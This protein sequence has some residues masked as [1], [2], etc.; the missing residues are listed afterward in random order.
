MS[1]SNTSSVDMGDGY[2]LSHL[3]TQQKNSTSGNSTIPTSVKNATRKEMS[4][5]AKAKAKKKAKLAKASRKKN[6]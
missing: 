4:A 3:A 2:K 5:A 6:K 1:S